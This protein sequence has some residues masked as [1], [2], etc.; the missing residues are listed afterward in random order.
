MGNVQRA[1]QERIQSGVGPGLTFFFPDKP[2]MLFGLV[3][4]LALAA[5]TVH[6]EN[7]R[8][9]EKQ[10]SVFFYF[11]FSSSSSKIFLFFFGSSLRRRQRSARQRRDA[12][13]RLGSS[14]RVGARPGRARGV[15]AV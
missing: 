15:G 10:K 5:S 1:S 8:T 7:A 9:R 13:G 2:Q 3:L 11:F 12:A 4:L 6:G 14:R